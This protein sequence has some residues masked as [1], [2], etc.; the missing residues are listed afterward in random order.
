MRSRSKADGHEH[1]HSV[2]HCH[3]VGDRNRFAHGKRFGNA[4][5]HRGSDCHRITDGRCF[6]H[7]GDHSD[8]KDDLG[9]GPTATATGTAVTPDEGSADPFAG[10]TCRTLSFEP[11]SASRSSATN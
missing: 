8:C 10:G 2:G 4:D 9:S 5:C 3:S 6:R 7:A 11:R 1:H